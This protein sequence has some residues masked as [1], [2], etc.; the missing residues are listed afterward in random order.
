MLGRRPRFTFAW[1]ENSR[2]SLVW[3]QPDHDVLLRSAC[4]RQRWPLESGLPRSVYCR[5]RS[6]CRRVLAVSNAVGQS[7]EGA[8]RSKRL[9]LRAGPAA[10]VGL[11]FCAFFL[12][13][14]WPVPDVNE[15][16][17]LGKAIRFWHPEWAKGDFFLDTADTHWV[18]NVTF[19]WVSLLTGPT[20]MAWIGRL[21]T[22]G[23]LA[24]AWRRLS[25]AV[26]P[27][28][29][30]AVLSGVLFAAGTDWCHMAGEWV[31]GGVEAKGFAYVL[32]LLG[33]EALVR[34]R[35]TAVWVLLGGAAFFHVLVGGW[36]VVAAAV[37]WLRS[38][39]RPSLRSMLPGLIAGLVLSLPGLVTGLRLD[40]HTP[41]EMVDLGRRIYVFQRLAHHLDLAQFPWFYVARFA[42]LIVVFGVLVRLVRIWERTEGVREGSPGARKEGRE[43]FQAELA[44]DRQRLVKFVVGAL[45]IALAGAAINL[46]APWHRSW[47]ASLL[48]F[49][50]YRLADVAVPLGAALFFTILVA[51]L[52]RAG[53]RWWRGL[54]AVGIVAAA[55]HVG[56]Y[57]VRRPWPIPPRADRG[58]SYVSWRLACNWVVH[59]GEIP[60][61]ARFLT[62]RQSQTFR[63]YTGRAEVATWKDIPQD[64]AS[65]V[66][67]WRRLRELHGTRRGTS[68]RGW[69][70]SLLELGPQRLRR[71]AEKY[72]AQYVL[73]EY[74]PEGPIRAKPLYHNQWYA[75]YR[76]S[77][78]E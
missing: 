11:L 29:W 53:Q 73:V 67:W 76:T 22:W 54:A 17:Y 77:D 44:A 18:F 40:W 42:A 46:L 36:A 33:L 65:I 31:I 10:E 41:A 60:R 7:G 16:Y 59:S 66:Q 5:D 43:G 6:V 37:V 8:G 70:R 20:A 15:P 12:Q 21:L 4:R 48:R 2:L 35:W 30:W 13:G 25:V 34:G 50:W 23:A 52:H 47:A 61:D 75:I 3:T 27:R 58:V 19:G 1:G 51:E 69:R 9:W 49:Y 57:A 38:A 39:D 56:H 24:W 26:L 55:L 64:A 78:L 62:P 32:V 14:A 71:L 68:G 28:P 45:A 72:Q 63:W 74:R